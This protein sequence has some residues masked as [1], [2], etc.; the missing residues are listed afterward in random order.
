[1]RG[2]RRAMLNALADYQL[3]LVQVAPESDDV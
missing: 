2:G 3:C 1:M